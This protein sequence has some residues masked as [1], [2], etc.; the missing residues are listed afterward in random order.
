M[1][2]V[3]TA[4]LLTAL[5]STT[6]WLLDV[7]FRRDQTRVLDDTVALIQT[8]FRQNEDLVET[9]QREIPLDLE[10]LHFHKYQLRIQDEKG[11][12][13][14]ETHRFPAMSAE[15]IEKM[16]VFSEGKLGE[17]T[18]WTQGDDSFLIVEAWAVR[19]KNSRE[20]IRLM[21]ALDTSQTTRT[22]TNYR[23]ALIVLV[24]LGVLL[25]A[26][27]AGL[28]SRRGLRPLSMMTRLVQR[29][30]VDQL[31]QRFSS[32]R[33]PQELVPLAQE[34]DRLLEEIQV[35]MERLSHFSTDLAHELRTP[36]TTMMLQAEVTLA[37]ER[38]LEVYQD[39]LG[40]SVEELERLSTLV[41]RLLLLARTEAARPHLEPQ[42]IAVRELVENLVE[43]HLTAHPRDQVVIQIP[44]EA[45]LVG[46]RRL[47]EMALGNL[48]SNTSKYST[49]P[50]RVEWIEHV[51]EWIIA[52]QDR[53]PGIDPE[54]LPYLFD[55]LY[56]VDTSRTSASHGLGLSLVRSAMR[57]HGGD[58]HLHS[59][60]G[61]GSRFQL[62]FPR[63]S[64]NTTFHSAG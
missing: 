31:H 51:N 47:V 63:P 43:Y 34:F 14:Y 58:V 44:A 20:R 27:L 30:K 4:L 38:S 35:G 18:V 12:K 36:L 64:D 9:L 3:S 59:V 16:P 22:L 32:R 29:L 60:L 10:A 42:K 28:I 5:G 15:A 52:V 19:E 48:L 8:I 23:R 26:F 41:E 56:R 55:R 13:L 57:A 53:G 21:V 61:Q 54:H 1:F 45:E 39:V 7:E 40:S 6:Y 50:V 33:W 49:F 11:K 62:H 25:A 17:G 37:Q 24:G 46:D 2:A